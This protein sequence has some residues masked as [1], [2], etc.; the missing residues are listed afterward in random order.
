MTMNAPLKPTDCDSLEAQPVVV[1]TPAAAGTDISREDVTFITM[2]A[3]GSVIH[4]L[5]NLFCLLTA[6][7]PH[8]AAKGAFHVGSAL[9]NL[10]ALC[11]LLNLRVAPYGY[12]TTPRGSRWGL[13][14]AFV[15]FIFAMFN[16]GAVVCSSLVEQH[17]PIAARGAGAGALTSTRAVVFPWT[18]GGLWGSWD[19]TQQRKWCDGHEG[20]D[21]SVGEQP[22]YER[23]CLFMSP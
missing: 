20:D 4:F 22:E 15:A 2:M 5:G 18:A 11:L 8:I 13:V 6:P 12:I 21:F 10:G 16:L 1:A 17:P 7:H 19:S 23:H 14:A 9:L 3:A